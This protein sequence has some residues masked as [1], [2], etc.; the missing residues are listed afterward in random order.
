MC[1]SEAAVLI[2]MSDFVGACK[3]AAGVGNAE[4]THGSFVCAEPAT[5]PL[6]YDVISAELA[7]DAAEPPPLHE[8]F[9]T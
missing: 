1:I 3:S 2:K 4:L 5:N 6:Q 9:E 7:I 8:V